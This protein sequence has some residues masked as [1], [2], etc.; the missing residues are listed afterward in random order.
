MA[1][2]ESIIRREKDLALALKTSHLRILAPVPGEALVGLEVPNPNPRNVSLQEVVVDQSFKSIATKGGLPI[3]VGLDTSG[4]PVSI[5]L[6]KVQ[7]LLVGGRTGSGKSVF[8]NALIASFLTCRSPSQ[9][10]LLLVDPKMVELTPYNSLPH[11]LAPVVVDMQMFKEVL[12]K[13]TIELNRRFSLLQLSRSRDIEA[14]NA[15]IEE[16]LPHIVLVVDELADVMAEL[17]EDAEEPLSKIAAMGRAA[18][19]H[20]V[21]CTQRP[22]VNAIPGK[23]KAN[24]PAR[25]AFA[26]ASGIDSRIILDQSGA[27]RL[28]GS[29]DC[30]LV[31]PDAAKPV[32]VQATFVSDDEIEKLVNS[33]A[34]RPVS[35]RVNRP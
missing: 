8:L 22:S 21:L 2:V 27:E 6:A 25:I 4:N 11:L 26:T 15:K 17:R 1:T 14:H 31:T 34:K 7:A 28:L 13:L 5:D 23:I 35:S 30:L 20:L 33:W 10:K 24:L 12:G 32:R 19:I 9:V 3:A 29:G 18:G 16:K